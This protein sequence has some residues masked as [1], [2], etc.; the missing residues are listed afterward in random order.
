MAQLRPSE[1][2]PAPRRSG[3][4][5]EQ[6]KKGTGGRGKQH[7]RYL[8]RTLLGLGSHSKTSLLGSCFVAPKVL[9]EEAASTEVVPRRLPKAPFYGA[10][11]LQTDIEIE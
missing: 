4:P 5:R 9:H 6:G 10:S 1:Q 11:A 2:V 7:Q 8:P 3:D